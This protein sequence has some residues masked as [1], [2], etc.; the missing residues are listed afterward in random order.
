MEQI[1]A[2]IVFALVLVFVWGTFKKLFK[3][4]FYA[5]IIISLLLAANMFFVYQ[6]INDLRKNFGV[7]EKKV[8]LKNDNE[9][10]TGLLLNEDAK[11]MTNKQLDDYSSYLKNNNYKN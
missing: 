10:L 5:G 3:L 4:L 11:L 1:V 9:I 8:I 6:D 7:S 2:I